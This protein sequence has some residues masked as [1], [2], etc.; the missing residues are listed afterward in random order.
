MET[1]PVVSSFRPS[2]VAKL[3]C[4]ALLLFAFSGCS[5]LKTW[6]DFSAKEDVDLQVPVKTLASQGM[7]D[8]SVGKYFTALEY[9]EKILDRYPFS[10]EAILAELKAADCNYFMGKYPEAL[11]QYKAFEERHPTN[12]AMPYVMFQK[13]M[14]NYKRIDRVD[15]DTVGATESIQLFKQ[16]LRAYPDSPYTAEAKA[17]IKAAQEFLANHEYCVVEYYLRTEKISEAQTRLKYML[18][19]YPDAAIAPKAKELLG[20]IEAGTPPRSNFTSWFPKV[21]LPDWSLFRPDSA[22]ESTSGPVER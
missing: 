22:E 15:R 20:L 7:D 14:C 5:S 10:P 19:V 11:V 6:F 16:L 4:L 21:S 18:A 3:I 8:Y 13:A 12:E 17:K 2:S 9:F 1:M